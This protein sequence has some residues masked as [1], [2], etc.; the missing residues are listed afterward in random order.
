MESTEGIKI[1]NRGV[2]EAGDTRD[3]D[4]GL[5]M[6]NCACK[7]WF[8]ER[9][10]KKKRKRRRK[11]EEENISKRYYEDPASSLCPDLG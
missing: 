7:I 1:R 4:E 8:R 2:V 6:T 9:R 5:V 10:K 11:E 3:G